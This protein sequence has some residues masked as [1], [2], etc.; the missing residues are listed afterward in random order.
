M[1]SELKN[2]I[3]EWINDEN[4][5]G[6]RKVFL[7]PC[8]IKEGEYLIKVQQSIKLTFE[9][10]SKK[11]N[12]SRKFQTFAQSDEKLNSFG[13]IVRFTKL[14]SVLENE[15]IN[16]YDNAI[17]ELFQNIEDKFDEFK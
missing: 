14:T 3:S 4:K 6:I 9:G 16:K 12:V 1:K 10:N 2:K 13:D 7:Q 5:V 11:I 17:G 15:F 8:P